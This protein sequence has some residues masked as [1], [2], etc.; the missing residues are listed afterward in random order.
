MS[1]SSCRCW[2]S[3][4]CSCSRCRR[5]RRVSSC[6]RRRE[7]CR[8]CSRGSGCWRYSCSC[9]CRWRWAG[10]WEIDIALPAAGRATGAIAEILS[11]NGIVSLHS[12]C[13]TC[14][15]VG[16]RAIN[17]IE[18][19]LPLIQ[20]QL[21][22]G[23]AAPREVLRPPLDVED[24]VG[25]SATYRCKDAEPT[26]DQIQVVPVRIDR[27]GHSRLRQAAVAKDARPVGKV[28]LTVGV[29]PHLSE[30]LVVQGERERQRDLDHRI[31]P[32]ITYIRRAWHDAAADLADRVLAAR[33][34]WR[35]SRR[36]GSRSRCCRSRR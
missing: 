30:D 36:G 26:V 29:E 18:A 34:C 14:V 13:G 35:R 1:S 28:R 24:A 15:A 9:T 7:R 25:S 23:T 19:A 8:S 6:R 5:R 32:V 31:I 12:S 3:C 16:K 4:S 2:R 10:W 27:V 22:V 11:K 21:K 17:D 33:R 20:P